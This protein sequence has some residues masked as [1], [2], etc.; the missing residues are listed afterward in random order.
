MAIH[1]SERRHGHQF[2]DD[3]DRFMDHIKLSINLR[4]AS[5]DRMCSGP[6]KTELRKESEEMVRDAEYMVYEMI[7][8]A[9]EEGAS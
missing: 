3:V 5:E 8:N 9:M 7:D 1:W 6:V 4:A 2:K